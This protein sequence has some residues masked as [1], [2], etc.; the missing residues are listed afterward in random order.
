[1]KNVEPIVAEVLLL[2]LSKLG[3]E[4]VFLV[5]GAQ[6]IPLVFKLYEEN[7]K[8]IPKPIIANHE[9]AAGFMALGY[10]RASG[11]MG[12]AISIGGPGAANMVDAGIVAK[13]DEVPVLFVTGNIP[14]ESFGKGEFQD[15]S[16]KGT[17][18]SSIFREA[19]GT[20]IVCGQPENLDNILLMIRKCYKEI[21]PIH[22]QIPISIQKS[23]YSPTIRDGV[24]IFNHNSL[25]KVD[26]HQ[27]EKIVF[28][29]GQ[30]VLN[31]I[32]QSKFKNFVTR[33]NIAVITDMKTR[34]ILSEKDSVSLGYVGFNSDIR[35]LEAF[36]INS[37]LSADL[38]ISVGVKKE[39]IHQYIDVTKMELSFIDAEI[40]DKWLDTLSFNPDSVR[41]KGIWL[42]ELNKF[43]QPQSR[44]LKISNKILY[45]EIINTIKGVFPKNTIY[46]LDSGQIRRAGSIFLTCH[47]PRSLIQSDTLSPMGFGICASI[48]AQI[49][50]P[51]K[52]VVCLFG[53]G[54]MKMH[55]IELSTAVR[56]KL[57]IIFVLCDNRSYASVKAPDIVKEL[58]E[59]NWKLFV[60]SFGMECYFVDNQANF[61][62][63]LKKK[64]ILKGPVLIWA[65]VPGLL[66]DELMETKTLEY[67]NWL[68]HI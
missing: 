35:A 60:K 29:V 66:D 57:P 34:G 27:K 38:I 45:S 23:G 26:L 30:R 42:N 67:K 2:E 68:S 51:Q 58:P 32:S 31:I 14:Q 46:C 40:F 20:S 10:A 54:S 4:Y 9:L 24:K 41:V 1:M 8:D 36:N 53:D 33:N 17:N 21:K 37:A 12:V 43:K 59:T 3:V 63:V 7:K 16:S 15:A 25:P 44:Q 55:G 22:I 18:D 50:F 64:V 5:P 48:G 61:L 49:A 52:P 28:L 47:V 13:I 19:I 56:Y 6:I 62:D 65:K 11:K 39:L